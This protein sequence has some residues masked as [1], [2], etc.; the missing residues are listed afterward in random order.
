MKHDMPLRGFMVEPELYGEFYKEAKSKRVGT[1][2]SYKFLQK[3]NRYF[4][5]DVVERNLGLGAGFLSTLYHSEYFNSE[6]QKAKFLG[7][8]LY[9]FPELGL[10][11]DLL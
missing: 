4:Y 6:D 11:E 10:E 2:F 3:I 9:V 5:W 1:M 8:F 7:I